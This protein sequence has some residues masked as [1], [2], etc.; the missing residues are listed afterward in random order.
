MR[1]TRVMDQGEEINPRKIRIGMMI[2]GAV[3]VISIVLLLAI[4]DPSARFVFGFVAVASLIQTWRI[5][6]QGKSLE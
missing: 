5:R 3:T 2:V 6:R 1:Q 4:D